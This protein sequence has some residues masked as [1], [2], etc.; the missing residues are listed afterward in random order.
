M[1]KAATKKRTT[2]ALL[3]SQAAEPTPPSE[4]SA[5][6]VEKGT[7][8]VPKRKASQRI[9]MKTHAITF[10]TEEAVERRI[11]SEISFGN[12]GQGKVLPRFEG[13]D[14]KIAGHNDEA[15]DDDFSIESLTKVT[16]VLR[17]MADTVVE[18]GE[19]MAEIGNRRTIG[20]II[21]KTFGN[22]VG[23]VN[24]VSSSQ[25]P[26]QEGLLDDDDIFNQPSFLDAVN[27]LEQ[28]FLQ[29]TKNYP[30]QPI[31][32]QSPH[33]ILTPCFDLGLSSTPTTAPAQDVPTAMN[34]Q[35]D[36]SI[37][38]EI[39]NIARD[40]QD[41][42]ERKIYGDEELETTPEE[43]F[44]REELF[45]HSGYHL[46]RD[47][48]QTLRSGELM[49]SLSSP[50]RR[51]AQVH[52]LHSSD[53]EPRVGGR[54]TFFT[55]SLSSQVLEELCTSWRPNSA[56]FRSDLS[57][58]GEFTPKTESPNSSIGS[59]PSPHS[60]KPLLFEPLHFRIMSAAETINC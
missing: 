60:N 39:Q 41:D 48:F 57:I 49:S 40:I 20:E 18:F 19:I 46:S 14:V 43:L 26:P 23:M 42:S 24:V 6:D 50:R 21:K 54:G 12:F 58:V 56:R 4:P 37:A 55:T 35:Q 2:K 51:R 52:F 29:T 31:R 1:K 28:A 8:S 3:D 22:I 44:D 38:I 17:K 13:V 9:E 25:P 27:A 10:W 59:C 15:V 45:I 36:Q 5:H 47:T 33:Q 32:S 34:Q 11:K 16:T 30:T 53:E 7:K